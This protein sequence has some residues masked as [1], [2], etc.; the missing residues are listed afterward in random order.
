M[1][2]KE[3]IT[4]IIAHTLHWGFEQT[5]DPSPVV[6][7]SCVR[8]NFGVLLLFRASFVGYSH[9]SLFMQFNAIFIL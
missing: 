1:L 5:P 4:I 9:S 7:N 8:L 2:A 6:H 3:G